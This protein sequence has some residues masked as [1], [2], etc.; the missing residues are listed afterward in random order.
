[1]DWALHQLPNTVLELFL[2]LKTAQ[3]QGDSNKLMK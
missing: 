3:S 2:L 1:M